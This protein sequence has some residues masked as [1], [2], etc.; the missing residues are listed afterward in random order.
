MSEEKVKASYLDKKGFSRFWDN[1]KTFI[2]KKSIKPITQ[3]EY[4]E[5][6][7]N[8]TI[9]E[10]QY[11]DIIDANP[12]YDSEVQIATVDQLGIVKPDGETIEIDEDGKLFINS[13][14]EELTL[15][16]DNWT[17]VAAP[18]ICDLDIETKYDVEVLLSNTATAE[19]V[20]AITNAQIAGNGTDNLLR[21]WGDKPTIDIP[22]VI[23]KV[24]K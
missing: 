17:G 23:R 1:L 18:Y 13:Q 11:Y 3:A 12:I 20:E 6:I 22:I 10:N 19:Q 4:N 5:L 14:T 16:A 21:A 8:G 15:F 9:D 24:V 2:N 7:K